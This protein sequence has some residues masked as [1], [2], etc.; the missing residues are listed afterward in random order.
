MVLKVFRIINLFSKRC[1]KYQIL[2]ALKADKKLKKINMIEETRINL[3]NH[4]ME[5]LTKMKFRKK[6]RQCRKYF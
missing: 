3:T 2:K 1:H 5:L 6:S 4:R